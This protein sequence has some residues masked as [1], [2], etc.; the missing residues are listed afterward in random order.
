[1]CTQLASLCQELHFVHFS[2]TITT[3]LFAVHPIHTEAVGSIVGRADL[4]ATF[5]FL[6]VLRLAI[7]FDETRS[8]TKSTN[9]KIILLAAVGVLFKETAI[10]ILPVVVLYKVLIRNKRAI[11]N[12]ISRIDVKVWNLIKMF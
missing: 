2:S 3:L 4:L 8:N 10:T 9:T 11:V 5:V 6:V 12:A 7:D 1:V